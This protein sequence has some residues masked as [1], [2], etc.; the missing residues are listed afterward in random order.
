MTFVGDRLEAYATAK[1]A[2]TALKCGPASLTWLE[3]FDRIEAAAAVI[4]QETI[5]GARVALALADP[6][7]LLIGLFASARTGRV[8]LI[9]D[10]EWPDSLMKSVLA[11]VSPAFF[12]QHGSQLFNPVSDQRTDGRP[13]EEALFF[14]GFT[15]GSS[16]FPKGYVRTHRSWLKS[17][18]LS[19]REFGNALNNRI[20]IAG[21]LTHSL[22]LY[23]AVYGLSGGHQ[24]VLMERFDPKEL[25]AELYRARDGAVLYATPTQV[26]YLGEA[27]R[28]NGPV[29]T[30]RQILVSGAKWQDGQRTAMA[31]IFPDACLTEFYGASE[32]SFISISRPGDYVPQG[33]VGR[34]AHGVQIAIGDPA[35][36]L[37][38][39]KA[40]EI[41][42]KSD[43]LFAGYL[44]GQSSD[45]RWAEGWL[46]VGDHG[47]LD[48]SGFL[49][50]TGRSNR[51]IVT[52]GLNVY[53]EEVEAQLLN[54]AAV[55]TAVVVGRPDPVRG[56]ILEAVVQLATPLDD[57]PDELLR[58]CRNVLAKGKLPKKI[59]IKNSLPLTA[60]GKPD[61][62]Q[63]TRDLMGPSQGGAV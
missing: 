61:I 8:A 9:V 54:H 6:M 46:T 22:H 49:F 44:C 63:I 55:A 1:P 34:A 57:A 15:S 11:E 56:Q 26:H 18:E 33:S 51:M 21:G 38:S 45:T 25:L 52:S 60:G 27:A 58:H 39:G 42:V 47:Y 50:L 35:H 59:H 13:D 41:W 31:S 7:S 28:R 17:F 36:P 48:G 32:T 3:L 16:G 20:V 37:P 10:P 24:V 4:C 62:P 30:V 43:L 29:D 19:D 40:G 23:G 53:P 2:D 14:A 12:I 5:A